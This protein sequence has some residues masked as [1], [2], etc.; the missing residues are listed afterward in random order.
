MS[1]ILI[2]R[3]KTARIY[4]IDG[5]PHAFARK[6]FSPVYPVRLWNWF[7]YNSPH[8]LTTE[9]G[10]KHA[11]WKR[12]L[13]HRLCK[14]LDCNAH[15]PDALQLSKSGFTSKHIDGRFP[16]RG[17]K[18]IFYTTIKKLE[19]FFA[20][21]GMPTWSFSRRNP[22]SSSNLIIR[23]NTVYFVDYE[24]SVPVPDS[25]G[26]IGYDTVYFE[27]V[28]DFI[29]GKRQ[30][31]LDKLGIRE[32]Q[33]LDEAFQMSRECYIQLDIKPKKITKFVNKKVSRL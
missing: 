22:F 29:S 17:D 3:G 7:F 8:P 16:T 27:D 28:G 33:H 23:D 13:A 1:E 2:G 6:E 18:R 21:I 11:Y 4:K 20:Y 12:R 9:V 14:C 24:Q 5:D 31:I 32:L 26:N 30:Q 15:I 25:K 10:H 19:D